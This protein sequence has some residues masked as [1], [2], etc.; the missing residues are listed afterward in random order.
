[1]VKIS[2][3]FY[4]LDDIEGK[5]EEILDL[6]DYEG[7]TKTEYALISDYLDRLIREPDQEVVD[8]LI[9]H[10]PLM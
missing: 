9:R 2:T 1:M 6:E 3:L 10:L 8:R 4:V 7:D 5:K